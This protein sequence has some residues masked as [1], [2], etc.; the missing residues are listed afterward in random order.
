M[1]EELQ[2]KDLELKEIFIKQEYEHL[3][4]NLNECS[5]ADVLEMTEVNWQVVKKY[6]DQGRNDLL[7]QH[8]NFVA[9]GSFITEYSGK[10][11]LFKDEEYKIKYAL[12][13]DIFEALQNENHS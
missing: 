9:Y 2:T 12:F 11:G 7:R 4:D 1:I 8:L 3:I 10:R 13:E 5:D 6:Y